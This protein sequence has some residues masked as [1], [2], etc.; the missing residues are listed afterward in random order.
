MHARFENFN[1]GRF[2]SI[3]PVRGN[4]KRPQSFNLFA[5]VGNNP[6]IRI[7][8][9]GL[10]PQAATA[11]GTYTDE[12]GDQQP[13]T[14][15][16]KDRPECKTDPQANKH[17]ESHGGGQSMRARNETDQDVL[18][19]PDLETITIGYGAVAGLSFAVLGEAG[20]YV[21][22]R[23]FDLGLY[24]TAAA[25]AG[26]AGV[27][28]TDRVG[29][30]TGWTVSVIAP[31]S[32]PESVNGQVAVVSPVVLGGGRLYEDGKAVGWSVSARTPGGAGVYGVATYTK[33]FS[34]RDFAWNVFNGFRR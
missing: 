33:T 11:D 9:L 6:I 24:A 14:D 23:P 18:P 2:L 12:N 5:Y 29:A 4:P 25:G 32:T 21:S 31:G 20:A 13:C 16:D 28:S 34:L 30:A 17:E 7:D 3:D 26:W 10:L 27:A 19:P 8:P 1:I 22:L 15:A